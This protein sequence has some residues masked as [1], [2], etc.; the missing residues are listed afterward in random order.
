MIAESSQPPRYYFALPRLCAWIRGGSAERSES[1][2]LEAYA[3][4]IVIFLVSYAT[5]LAHVAP[6]VLTAFLLLFFTWIVWLI[7]FHMNSLIVRAFRATG[8]FRTMSNARAQNIIIGVETT[9][10]AL[11]LIADSGSA[12]LAWFWIALVALNLLAAIA[13]R[14]LSAADA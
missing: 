11:F 9:V 14:A 4:G 2:S 5:V 3:V 13:L 12:L 7:I 1:N 6:N 10:C 8:V